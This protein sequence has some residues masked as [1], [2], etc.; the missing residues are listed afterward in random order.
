MNASGKV[1]FVV[2]LHT[3]EGRQDEFLALL[4]PL[5]DA[6]RHEKTFINAVLHRDAADPTRFMLYE[7][8]ADLADVTDVQMKR[9]YRAAYEAAL[10]DLLRVPRQVQFWQPLR[11]DFKVF[12]D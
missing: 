7:T 9:D 2:S 11:G 10:P 3:K 12:A 1:V 6:M 8:W 5:L 4:T